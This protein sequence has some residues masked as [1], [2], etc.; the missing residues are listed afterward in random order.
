MRVLIASFLAAAYPLKLLARL[1]LPLCS[2]RFATLISIW[3]RK[4]LRS[5]GMMRVVWMVVMTSG[6]LNQREEKSMPDSAP[7]ARLCHR[8]A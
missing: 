1:L 6:L 4:A 5:A 2:A 7:D 8:L 3:Y